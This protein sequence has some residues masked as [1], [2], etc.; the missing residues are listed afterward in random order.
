MEQ[1]VPEPEQKEEAKEPGAKA[2]D[3]EK[4]EDNKNL[5]AKDEPN[6]APNEEAKQ[7][8]GA[9]KA[10]SGEKGEG[11]SNDKSEPVE[12]I[13]QPKAEGDDQAKNDEQEKDEAKPSDEVA[14]PEEEK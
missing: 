10:E 3:Q 8:A 12:D 5:D 4:V 13:Q 2:P 1:P 6:D 7:V 9:D 14:K 11:V